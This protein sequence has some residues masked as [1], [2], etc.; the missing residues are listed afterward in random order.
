MVMVETVYNIARSGLLHPSGQEGCCVPPWGLFHA[1]LETEVNSAVSVVSFNPIIMANPTEHQTIY[2]T[3]MRIKE[4]MNNLGQTNVPV[5]FDMGLLT[6]ALEITWANHEELSGVIPCYGGMHL[7][8]STIAAIGHL[9][10]DAGLKSLLQESGV[11]A[12]GSVQRILAGKVFDRALYALKLI[13]EA[14]SARLIANFTEWCK[15]TATDLIPN[16]TELLQEMDQTLSNSGKNTVDKERLCAIIDKIGAEIQPQLDAFREH[17]RATSPTFQLWDDFLFKVLQPV[18]IFI[19]STRIGAWDVQQSTVTHLL[20]LLFITNRSNY[21]KYMPVVMLQMRRLPVT[22]RD[23]FRDGHFVS[24]LSEGKFNA[25][26]MDYTIEATENKTLKGSGGIIGLT[27]R[28]PALLRWFL[29]RPVTA[30][31]SEQVRQNVGGC[32]DKDPSY[33]MGPKHANRWDADVNKMVAMFAGGSYIDPFDVS[34][35]PAKL[36]N[37]AT[38][39]AAPPAVQASMLGAIDTGCKLLDKFVAERLVVSTDGRK[40]S[41][42]DTLP[43]SP[44]KTMNEMKK[45]LRVNN[46]DITI[47]LQEESPAHARPVV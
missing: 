44:L 17:G 10:G 13:D 47:K 26:W 27:L 21:A 24:K 42:Y 36:V 25:V 18:K 4:A 16:V 8:M 12:T 31:Y 23:S 5:V 34:D 46:K 14:L 3:L 28:G 40:K 41:F 29:S 1:A 22:V 2:T 30:Q 20:P 37:F 33:H 32:G 9:Y 35:P 7:L 38:G 45:T 15:S 39:A 43:R 19:S 6:K 11:F